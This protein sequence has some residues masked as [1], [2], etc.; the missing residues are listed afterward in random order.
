MLLEF[1]TANYRSINERRYF[2]MIGKGISDE[3]LDNIIEVKNNKVLKTAAI[4]GAN[5]SGKS[6]II[7]AMHEMEHIVLSSVKL[8]DN[9]KLNYEP[10][11]LSKSED[12]PSLFE[13]VF[14]QNA[15]KYRY[16]FELNSEKI[17]SEWLYRATLSGK[18]NELFYRE[19]NKIEYNNKLFAEA[20]DNDKMINKI[21]SN[22]LLISLCA[23]LGGE[24][25]NKII[26][27]FQKSI[28]ILSG[29]STEAYSGYSKLMLHKKIN[30]CDDAKAF[31][32]RLQLGF[33]DLECIEMEF[34]EAQ[35]SNDMPKELKERLLKEL[36][37]KKSIELYSIHNVYDEVGNIVDKI[38]LEVEDVE[39]EGTKKLIELS[40]PIFDTLLEGKT[41][42]IDELDSK[43]H[44]HITL[45]IINLFNSPE[46]NRKGAQL[47][48]T[49]HD[50]NLLSSNLF[51]RDQI[52]F[53]EKDQLEQTDLYNMMDIILPDGCP[54]RK[55][56]N[57]EK[58][59]IAGRY[60][61]I[62][63]IINE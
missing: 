8:N 62:P 23:Q 53:T 22:R 48:F 7:K 50:T 31:F 16:G 17:I 5:S 13:V 43:L 55:D 33:K 32:K 1:S 34:D 40:G 29:I 47:I 35:L 39:S 30:G 52:W 28:N 11:L 19:L 21:N 49:T 45:H 36:K 44:P 63:Y 2:S 54:P 9:D 37:G 59:Y 25:S 24:E 4:Y 41:L 6:N 26:S 57:F 18:E 15:Y 42:V 27:W 12:K 46:T 38:S 51:R 61:A 20:T 14:I 3:P 58:N 60:G 56:S 10:F